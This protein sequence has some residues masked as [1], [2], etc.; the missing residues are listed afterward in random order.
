M[1]EP[2]DLGSPRVLEDSMP[3]NI[4]GLDMPVSSCRVKGQ[5]P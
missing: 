2:A 1:S 3:E 5:G 4:E